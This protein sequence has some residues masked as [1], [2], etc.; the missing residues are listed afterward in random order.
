MSNRDWIHA[1]AFGCCVVLGI[2]FGLAAVYYSQPIPWQNTKHPTE[3][4]QTKQQLY[5][6]DEVA[7]DAAKWISSVK[8]QGIPEVPCPDKKEDCTEPFHNAMD[9][10]A[11]WATAD[12]ATSMVWLTGAQIVVGLLGFGAL[13]YSLYLTRQSLEVTRDTARK[14]LRAYIWGN[15]NHIEGLKAGSPIS[16][17]F[18]IK[19]DGETPAHKVSH[20]GLIDILP[21]PLPSNHSFPTL[22]PANSSVS[23]V[24]KG[25]DLKGWAQ[26]KRVF[27]QSEINASMQIG[28]NYRVYVFGLIKYE[29]IF[30]D[31]Q[32][33]KFCV[34]LQPNP[35]I[36]QVII[37]KLTTVEINFEHYSKY[38]EA[39]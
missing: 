38:N 24:H 15:T 19:N 25:Q 6:Y 27:Q 9:L 30:N 26:S 7:K 32:H 4:A 8:D 35:A 21:Y 10:A 29:D 1:F 39:T 18:Q 28:G 12:A 34:T 33:T 14:Q 5:S 31:A 20:G 11:Q 16:V 37:G 22:S 23:S 2:T 3:T 13:A 17:A 36:L